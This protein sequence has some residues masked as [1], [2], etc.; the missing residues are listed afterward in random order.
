MGI[1]KLLLI[2]TVAA[3]VFASL[4]VAN[5][6][7]LDTNINKELDVM[8]H[9]GL[10]IEMTPAMRKRVNNFLIPKLSIPTKLSIINSENTRL[11]HRCD[12]SSTTTTGKEEL[13][14]PTPSEK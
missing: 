8:K 7:Y 6:N 4:F 11:N 1:F 10:R 5:S 12:A 14:L 13:T 9:L 2:V 3:V